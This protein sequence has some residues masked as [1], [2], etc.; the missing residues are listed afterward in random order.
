ML[1]G[2]EP[3]QP[4]TVHT[5]VGTQAYRCAGAR[6]GIK[7]GPLALPVGRAAAGL[8]RTPILAIR[9][10]LRA[11]QAQGRTRTC[12]RAARSFNPGLTQNSSTAAGRP[13]NRYCLL[14]PATRLPPEAAPP[15]LLP[16]CRRRSHRAPADWALGH[17]VRTAGCC[18]S[19]HQKRTPHSVEHSWQAGKWSKRVDGSA[20]RRGREVAQHPECA[21]KDVGRP[22]GS[23]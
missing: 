21:C 10:A 13:H 7:A 15:P 9:D 3:S 11:G 23:Q 14:M 12:S 4:S 17:R 8:A 6:V 19:W 2:S 1:A 22:L 16:S 18:S 5:G 20:K